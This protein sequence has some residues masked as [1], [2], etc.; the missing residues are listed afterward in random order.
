MTRPERFD[1]LFEPIQIGPKTMRNRFYQTPQCTGFGDVFPGG[2][3]YHRG[4]K[5]EGGWAVV[6]TEATTI[7]PEFDW[8]GQM[9]PSRIWDDDDVRNWSL[10]TE[11]VH[12]HDS[13]AGMELHAGGAFI[14]GFDSRIPARHVHNRIEEAAWFGAVQAMDKRDIREIQ[15]MYVAAALRAL[16]AGFDIVNIHGAEIGGMPVQFLMNIHNQRTDEYGGSLENRARF[17]METLEM[18]REAVGDEMAVAARFC[19]DSLHGTDEGIRVDEEGVGF[20]ELADHLVDFWDLQVGGENVEL[21]IKDAGPSRFYQ[22]NFQADWVRKV[23]PHTAKPIVGVGRFTTPDTILEVVTSGQVDI[24]GAARPTISDPFLPKKIE[25]GRFE[26][27]RECIGCNV[28]VSRVNARWTLICTQNATA[29]EEYKRGWHPERF[30]PAKNLEKSVLIVGAGPA[31]LECATVLGKR[32]FRNVHLVEGAESAGGHLRW[33]ADLPGMS[34][35]RRV[36]DWRLTQIE[37][38]RDIALVTNTELS[39]G[40][41]LEYGADIIVVATGSSWDRTGLNGFSHSSLVD[42]AD[43][44]AYTPEDIL[45]DQRELSGDRVVIFDVEGYF[46]GVSLAEQ[47][48]RAGHD[49]TVVT[50]HLEAGPYMRLTGE[51]VHMRPLLEKLGVRLITEHMVTRVRDGE[52]TVTQ[53]YVPDRS[54]SLAADAIVMTTQRLSNDGLWLALQEMVDSSE[55]SAPDLYRIGDCTTPRM[56]AADAV[57]DGHRL[58]REIDTADPSVPLPFIRERRIVGNSSDQQLES[59]LARNRDAQDRSR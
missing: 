1:I 37:K 7:G 31:G 12:E 46:M 11:K 53:A 13:L 26:D 51:I 5:A 14:T 36:V 39:A 6:N 52:V 15:E 49:V 40:E 22:E 19:V 29:G 10:M 45:R 21:W 23:R 38:C 32:G 34:H 4:V 44:M 43:A 2:Q 57:F 59:V 17:W 55:P 3:A 24:V 18:V 20:I 16:A 33:V 8:A 50:P 47:L 56:L 30:T 9:T 58:A 41:V 42:D 28:C 25:E 54:R 48:A 35:W 27:I